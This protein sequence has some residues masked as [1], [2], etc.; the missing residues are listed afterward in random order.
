MKEI[1]VKQFT[2]TVNTVSLLTVCLNDPGREGFD[3]TLLR[4]R[5]R[6]A[7]AIDG[8]KQGDVIKLEDA[9]YVTAQNA[10]KGVRWASRD[11]H[12]IAFAEQF[13]L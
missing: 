9:D 12:L 10:I 7:K 5:E 1:P 13:G 6:V 3:L 4:A 8:L 2:D 11:K